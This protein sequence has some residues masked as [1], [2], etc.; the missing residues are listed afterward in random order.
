[1]QLVVWFSGRIAFADAGATVILTDIND[2][3]EQAKA[4][5]QKGQKAVA[6]CCNVTNE[7][8]V[9][10]TIKQVIS[11]FGRIDFAFN[12]QEYK[13]QLSNFQM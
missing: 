6:I 7:K 2:P 10:I 9:E 1:M 3:I 5:V 8:E 13:V 11:E 4:I 12:N